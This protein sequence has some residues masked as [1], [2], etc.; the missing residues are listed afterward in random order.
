[1]PDIDAT[2]YA[3]LQ[4]E[5]DATPEAC[6]SCD[7]PPVILEDVA[8]GAFSVGCRQAFFARFPD[9]AACVDHPTVVMG[10][11]SR[12]EALASWNEWVFSRRAM[13]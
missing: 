3:G 5:P 4:S 1:M 7:K 12:A 11:K 10:A 2:D 6:P 9:E 13:R 8:S